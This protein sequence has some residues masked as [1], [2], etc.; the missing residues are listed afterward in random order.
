MSALR[1]HH[2]WAPDYIRVEEPGFDKYTTAKLKQ[3][4]YDIVKKNLGCRIQAISRTNGVLTGV[5]DPRGEG[6]SSGI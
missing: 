3:Y 5:S 6:S 1:F 4:G 2:Q